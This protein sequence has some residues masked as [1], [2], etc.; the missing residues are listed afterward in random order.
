MAY[1]VIRF[2]K[3]FVVTKPCVPWQALILTSGSRANVVT[4]KGISKAFCKKKALFP[5]KT[6]GQLYFLYQILEN[7]VSVQLILDTYHS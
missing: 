1:K 7:I 2:V 5:Y 6:I 3:F 4:L